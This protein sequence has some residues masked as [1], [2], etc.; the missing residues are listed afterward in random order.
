MTTGTSHAA[1]GDRGDPTQ[2]QAPAADFAGQ[3][4]DRQGAAGQAQEAAQQVAQQA[5]EKAQQAASA[6]RGTVRDQLDQRSSQLADQINRQAS[7]LRAVSGSLREQGKEG[8]ASAA[9]RVAEHA[10]RV[11]GYLRDRRSD[12]LLA[13]AEDFGRRQPWAVVAGGLALGFAASRFLKAS[14]RRRYAARGGQP[15]ASSSAGYGPGP[16]PPQPPPTV[17][18]PGLPPPG[19][20]TLGA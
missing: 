16:I 15:A 20:A 5:Q 13:D 6:A 8:P 2:T 14:S 18:G 10:E 17:G 12:D 1:T 11:G 9:D 4:D 19:P 3:G 7:D